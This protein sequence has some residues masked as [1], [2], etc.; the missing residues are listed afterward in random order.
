MFAAPGPERHWREGALLA[1]AAAK[2]VTAA[3]TVD[4]PVACGAPVHV[5]AARNEQVARSATSEVPRR[6]DMWRGGV[7]V[8]RR[9]V[10]FIQARERERLVL[11]K[12]DTP[13]S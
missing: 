3:V 11:V 12:H 1:D 2:G 13:S 8:G 9:C 4:G 5:A 10:H 7:R 6:L